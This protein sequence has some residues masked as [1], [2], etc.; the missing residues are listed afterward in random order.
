MQLW[1]CHRTGCAGA[2]DHLTTLYRIV[3][4]D[5]NFAGVRVGRNETVGMADQDQVAVT[6]KLAAGIGDHAILRRAH[7]GSFWYRKIDSIVQL[8]AREL[9]PEACDHPSARRPAKGRRPAAR[10]RTNVPVV[11]GLG[12]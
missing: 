5:Q 12:W 10:R 6:A 7:R 1:R 3:A 11:A 4:F 2:R 9:L 8:T